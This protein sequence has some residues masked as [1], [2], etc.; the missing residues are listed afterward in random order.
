MSRRNDTLD[1]KAEAELAALDR[2]LSGAGD[3]DP[4]WAALVADVRREEPVMR[5]TFRADLARDVAAG[6]PRGGRGAGS[7]RVGRMRAWLRRGL[8]PALAVSACLALGG[9]LVTSPPGGGD[10]PMFD[11][12]GGGGGSAAQS[13][14]SGRSA[15]APEAG[16]GAAAD[17]AGDES[18]AGAEPSAAAPPAGSALA[19]PADPSAAGSLGGTRRV[20]RSTAL[21]LTTPPEDFQD[22]VNGLVRETKG[23]GGVVASSEVTAA[24]DGGS[25]NFV[26]RVPDDRADATV[27]RLGKLADIASLS[28]STQDI[29]GTYTSAR[30][31]LQDARDE[32]EALLRAL[33]RA[34]TAREA[35]V[36]ERRLRRAR[37]R[38]SRL[39]GDLRSL[40][41]RTTSSR[42]D[43]SVETRGE[44]VG[45]G[46]WTPGDAARDA[47]R[48]LEFV[49]G[50]ALVA[51][52]VLLPFALL[53]LL[54]VGARRARR[55]RRESVLGAA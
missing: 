38:I 54:G 41:R 21:A 40:R 3:A 24:G 30:D 17:G 22:V 48:V 34:D 43:V 16:G 23:A 36:L 2:A 14:S 5:P 50:V 9:V 39:E 37:S 4:A 1:P 11:A 44:G 45:A 10:D 6:F 42:I 49:A 26:L 8:L 31:R 18:A 19:P 35:D 28:E 55:R 53:A 7:A 13:G 20:E 25:A 32:R 12:A 46:V 47:L 33:G 27:A 51:G 52:A 29:T 15:G